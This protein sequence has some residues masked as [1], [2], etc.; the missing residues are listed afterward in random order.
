MPCT[1]I[2]QHDMVLD[3]WKEYYC[4]T[5]SLSV[6]ASF[7][8]SPASCLCIKTKNGRCH[9]VGSEEI[10][11]RMSWSNAV[12]V[13]VCSR[14]LRACRVKIFICP[15]TVRLLIYTY[16]TGPIGFF[17]SDGI[18]SDW[19][20]DSVQAC[21]SDPAVPAR[22]RLR[23][24]S[25]SDYTVPRTRTRLGDRAFSV[26][27]PVVTCMKQSTSSSSWSWHAFV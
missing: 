11:I 13:E 12:F 22:T 1:E 15:R 9:E 20:T 26:A 23:S 2:A 4:S 18:K 7:W 19:T 5:I 17:W 27:G 10:T 24:A 16:Y 6:S 14:D 3:C 8:I 21:N 25:S